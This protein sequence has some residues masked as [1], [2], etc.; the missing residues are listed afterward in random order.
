MVKYTKIPVI[1][2]VDSRIEEGLLGGY[3]VSMNHSGL[4][5]GQMATK[6]IAGT[7]PATIPVADSP[8]IYYINEGDT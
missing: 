7:D 1:R 8:N 2:M 5:A 4:L 6:I 3:V